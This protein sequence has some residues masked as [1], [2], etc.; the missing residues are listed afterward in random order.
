MFSKRK[1]HREINLMPPPML[2]RQRLAATIKKAVAMQ[3]TIV[4]AAVLAVFL[5]TQAEER[6]QEEFAAIRQKLLAR[7]AEHMYIQALQR[8]SCQLSYDFFSSHSIRQINPDALRVIYDETPGGA[9]LLSI[10]YRSATAIINGLA[11][12]FAAVQTH[13]TGILQS[14]LFTDVEF[15]EI[16]LQEDGRFSYILVAILSQDDCCAYHVEL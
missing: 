15:G 3:L 5:F 14:P 7:E 8:P 6:R 13:R 11:N 9:T 1:R 2:A 10:E 4:L 12:D 16:I